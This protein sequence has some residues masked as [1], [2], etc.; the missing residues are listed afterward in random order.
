MS[1]AGEDGMHLV[2]TIIIIAAVLLLTMK[3]FSDHEGRYT[4]VDAY[5]Q[6]YASAD[7]AAELLSR[8]YPLKKDFD[9]FIRVLDNEKIKEKLS[10]GSC[11]DI[12]IGCSGVCVIDRKTKEKW[13]CGSPQCVSST[14]DRSLNIVANARIPVALR[15]S[16]SQ[17]DPGVL[18][19]SVEV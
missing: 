9:Q 1:I 19:V 18:E 6:A 2:F 7:K 11:S 10:G 5:R 16:E 12:C 13:F 3:S 17:Y 14:A 8:E 15:V 4:A